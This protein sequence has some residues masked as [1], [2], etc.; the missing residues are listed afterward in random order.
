MKARFLNVVLV[1][2][3]F[4]AFALTVRAQTSSSGSGQPA[5]FSP[6]DIDGVWMILNGPAGGPQLV[7]PNAHPPF[8][9]WGKAK[10][11]KTFPSLGP[12]DVPGKENDPIL[13]CYP[14]GVPKILGA[15][16]P[17]EIVTL[18]D[19]VL[20]TFEK[21]HDWRQIW[22][23]GKKHNEGDDP[24]FNGHSVGHWE[25]DTFVVE[26]TGF[27]DIP[28]LDYFGDPFSDQMHLTEYYKR[29]D[30]NTLSISVTI[31]D[32]KTYTTVWVGKPHL[33]KF[34]PDWALQ[35]YFCTIDDIKQY[36]K[37]L[38]FPAGADNKSGAA[39]KSNKK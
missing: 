10:F 20:E 39:S 36:D 23:D 26:T 21:D 14:D 31:N 6:H 28:W 35:E 38:R 25:G 2:L 11:D 19:R 13:E 30:R 15:P 34:E 29:V 18:K 33:Y 22:T 12:R 3:V 1:L 24:T 32:P 17:F 9:P 4:A 8:T 27:N 16:H 37:D 7:D 5:D